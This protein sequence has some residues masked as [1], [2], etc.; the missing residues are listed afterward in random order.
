MNKNRQ[1]L[2][3]FVYFVVPL[4]ADKEI[5]NFKP[6]IMEKKFL[7][8]LVMLMTAVSGAWANW[9]GKTYTVTADETIN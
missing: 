9:D 5:M 4:H 1:F 3:S 7:S 6:E 8:L 2:W